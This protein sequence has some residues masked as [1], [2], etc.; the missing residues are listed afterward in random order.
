MSNFYIDARVSKY[1]GDPFR[2]IAELDMQNEL[3]TITRIKKAYKPAPLSFDGRTPEQVA[4][5]KNVLANTVVVVDN[6]SAFK[7]YDT[8]FIES[9]HL[10]EAVS[11]Y[12]NFKNTGVLKNEL[13]VDP[14]SVVEVRKLD[15]KGSVY[16]LNSDEIQNEHVAILLC[17]WSALKIKNMSSLMDS[18][19]H[20]EDDIDS[21]NTP[22]SL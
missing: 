18:E 3:L 15:M 5:I 11:A 17:C 6:P 14:A 10:N 8:L 13:G 1:A 21:F 4:L 22:F 9:E 20:T 19:Q 12:L 7:E 2:V 16:E